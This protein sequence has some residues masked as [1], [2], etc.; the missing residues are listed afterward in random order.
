MDSAE[1]AKRGRGHL[2]GIQEIGRGNTKCCVLLIFFSFSRS[3][4]GGFLEG[5]RKGIIRLNS[6]V[7][8]GPGLLWSALG[9]GAGSCRVLPARVLVERR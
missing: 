2:Y 3:A 4:V 6:D 5:E 7:V 8:W 9:G 1:V